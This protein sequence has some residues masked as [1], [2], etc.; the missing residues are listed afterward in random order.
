[1][2]ISDI[3]QK[4]I[5]VRSH[6]R[7]YVKSH[8]DKGSVADN[9]RNESVRFLIDHWEPKEFQRVSI[10]YNGRMYVIDVNYDKRG[11]YLGEPYP[12]HRVYV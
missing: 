9:D 1:M 7:R 2:G 11:V 3:Y 8:I 5:E 12:V 4:G 6:L 10:R